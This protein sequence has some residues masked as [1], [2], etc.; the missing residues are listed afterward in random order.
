ML[1]DDSFL[2]PFLNLFSTFLCFLDDN[3]SLEDE[4]TAGSQE[5]RQTERKK[6]GFTKTFNQIMHSYNGCHKKIK[7]TFFKDC[8]TPKHPH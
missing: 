4:L 5:K 1:L 8:N 2:L 6:G 7:T 3:G